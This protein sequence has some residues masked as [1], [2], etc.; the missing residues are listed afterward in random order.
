MLVA[1]VLPFYH[2]VT[3]AKAPFNENA[4]NTVEHL[5]WTFGCAVVV[6]VLAIVIF[7]HKMK[8]DVK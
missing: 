1:S 4:E 7:Q 8:K 6:Y 5:L 2:G 3:L